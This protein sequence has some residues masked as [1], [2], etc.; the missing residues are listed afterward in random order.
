MVYYKVYGRR[1]FG[2]RRRF[3]SSRRSFRRRAIGSGGYKRFP[4]SKR[5][6]SSFA[7]R[8]FL[9]AR[10]TV[11]NAAETKS[12][13]TAIQSAMSP[14]QPHWWFRLGYPAPGSL[15]YQRVGTEI[16]LR[17]IEIAVEMSGNIG[18][19]IPYRLLVVGM[20]PVSAID[21]SPAIPMAD[22]FEN[23]WYAAPYSKQFTEFKRKKVYYDRLFT[24]LPVDTQ[25]GGGV[26]RYVRR[27]IVKTRNRVTGFSD[28]PDIAVLSTDWCYY[29]CV[30]KLAGYTFSILGTVVMKYTDA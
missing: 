26:S 20:P 4:T 25:F 30:A 16:T 6:L 3:G 2:F 13:T 27:F 7:R 24:M 8:R 11:Q 17:N 29:V 22:W 23:Q 1:R 19:A 28:E 5:K 15:S 14:A 12:V 9:S 21:E 10:R 18:L